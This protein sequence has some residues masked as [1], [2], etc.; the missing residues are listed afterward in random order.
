MLMIAGQIALVIA[1]VFAGAAYYVGWVEHPARLALDDRAAVMQ[2]QP[3][4]R[5]GARMQASLAVIGFLFGLLAW[6]QSQDWPW[7]VGALLLLA[8]W[9]WTLIAIRPTNAALKAAE[10]EA[11]GEDTRALLVRWGRLHAVRTGLGV[12]SVLVFLWASLRPLAP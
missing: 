3:A 7:I 8:N 12:A 1:A 2:W 11:A 10:P 4:Y 5:R 6:W 9:P